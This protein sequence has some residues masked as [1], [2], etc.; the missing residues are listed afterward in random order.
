MFLPAPSGQSP[1]NAGTHGDSYGAVFVRADETTVDAV[2]EAVRALA[3][4][5]WIAP[6]RDGWIVVL[7]DPGD[8][9]VAIGRRGIVEVGAALA[10]TLTVAAIAMRVRR[11]RQ[12]G[13]VAWQGSGELGRYCSDPSQE[14]QSD[15]DVISEPVGAESAV[16]FAELCGRAEVAEKLIEVLDEELDS[17]SVFESERLIAVLRMLELPSWLV[18]SAALPRDIPTGPRADELTRLRDGRPGVAGVARNAFVRRVRRRRSPPPVIADPPRSGM[19][20]YD[21]WLM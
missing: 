10:A 1:D 18:A 5:G 7:G 14:P 8:G 21:P 4:T 9:V 3:F 19:S 11:D 20:G 16:D 13:I 6:P 15:D 12:L 2:V 17:D